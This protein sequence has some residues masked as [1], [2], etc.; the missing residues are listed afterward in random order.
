[1][2]KAE[3]DSCHR[4]IVPPDKHISI[5]QIVVMDPQGSRGI[6]DVH[7]CSC[8]CLNKLTAKLWDSPKL[9][10]PNAN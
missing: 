8:E 1:M 6:K 9:V 10:M 2:L 4:P 7:A 3:C 5:P